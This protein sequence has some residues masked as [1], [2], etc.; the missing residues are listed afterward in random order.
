VILTVL[1]EPSKNGV[2]KGKLLVDG[3]EEC[4]TLEDVVRE[5]PNQDTPQNEGKVYG[6]TAIPPDL[7]EPPQR[8]RVVLTKSAKFGKVLPEVLNV[9]GYTGVRIHGGVTEKHTLGCILVGTHHEGDQ[10]RGSKDAMTE[11]MALL[12]TVLEGG[13]QVWLEIVNPA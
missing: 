6:E 4:V 11:L 12:S 1:R 13:E 10:L 3:S 8:Y 2:T 5:D 7:G 9:P